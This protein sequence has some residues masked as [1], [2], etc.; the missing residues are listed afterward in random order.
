MSIK[1]KWINKCWYIHT[2]ECKHY[3]GM[4]YG[5]KTDKSQKHDVE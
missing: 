3:K 2:M 4:N 5:Y 1:V